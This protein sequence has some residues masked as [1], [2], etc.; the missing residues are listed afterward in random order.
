MSAWKRSLTER[1]ASPLFEPADKT[2]EVEV[3]MVARYRYTWFFDGIQA[4]NTWIGDMVLIFMN[5]LLKGSL[6]NLLL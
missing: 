6:E 2:K 1:A 4:D 3:R 5:Y